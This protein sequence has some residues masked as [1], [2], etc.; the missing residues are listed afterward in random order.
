MFLK[1]NA[2]NTSN[3]QEVCYANNLR[4]MASS[5]LYVHIYIFVPFFFKIF[6]AHYAFEY[7][8]YVLKKDSSH[9]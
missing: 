2:F 4:F 7:E 1:T 8:Y 3:S 9:M 5:F 6:F